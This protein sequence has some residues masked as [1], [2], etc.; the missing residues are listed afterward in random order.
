MWTKT[1]F[2]QLFNINLVII[3][4]NHLGSNLYILYFYNINNP[5]EKHI[6][7]IPCRSE[8][9]LWIHTLH[10]QLVTIFCILLTKLR[11]ISSSSH[12]IC[13]L[14]T[15]DIFCLLAWPNIKLLKSQYNKLDIHSKKK[16]KSS[17]DIDC[18]L[19][20]NKIQREVR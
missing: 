4:Y 14:V 13:P 19:K 10:H 2:Y 16:K 5:N 3:W 6:I 17:L 11:L 7:K 9:S 20:R 15:G 8:P 18:F 12:I 1:D